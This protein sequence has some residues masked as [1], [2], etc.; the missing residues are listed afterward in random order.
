MLASIHIAQ[1]RELWSSMQGKFSGETLGCRD[2][3][4][5]T[6]FSLKCINTVH[7]DMTH[8]F[9]IF[10]CS[11][12][13]LS[14]QH[15]S[16]P[17]IQPPRFSYFTLSPPPVLQN[18]LRNLLCCFLSIS[19]FS[20]LLSHL[21][22]FAL[23]PSTCPFSPL[24]SLY[25]SN[26]TCLFAELREYPGRPRLLFGF[27]RWRPRFLVEASWDRAGE[28]GSKAHMYTRRNKHV[29]AASFQLDCRGQ[30]FGER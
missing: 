27:W 24:R 16:F 15:P 10:K 13:F 23:F 1:Y 25:F 17:G 28:G 4:T 11:P 19:I 20:L 22:C 30:H 8:F 5:A 9:N 12:L 3:F 6:H 29:I 14:I 18:I 7:I 21:K 26:P 2:W